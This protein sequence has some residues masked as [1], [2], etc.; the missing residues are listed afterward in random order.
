MKSTWLFL[1]LFAGQGT[2]FAQCAEVVRPKLSESTRREFE[3]RLAEAESRYR[4]DNNAEAM[5]WFGRRMAYLG[6]YEDAIRIFSEGI[7]R[8]PHDA[9]LYRHRGHRYITLRCFDSAIADL[10]KAA[11]LTKRKPDEI[12][13]DGL[14]NAKNIPTSTL[15]TNIWYHLGL[16]HYLRGEYR[17]AQVAFEKCLRLSRNPDMYVATANWLYVTLRRLSRDRDAAAILATVLRDAVLIENHDY[18]QILLLYSDRPEITDPVAYLEERKTGLGL[19]S[20]GFG[21]GN[22]LRL[23]GETEKARAVFEQV[24]KGDQWASFGYMA[25]EAALKEMGLR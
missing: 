22:Y 23:R 19:A 25:S 18:L 1:L 9:R 15:Q 14:P 5:I 7:S 3:T 17:K 10:V 4:S 8:W 20:F 6:K 11:R 21:L 13:P 16:A 12:E 24:I 2:A